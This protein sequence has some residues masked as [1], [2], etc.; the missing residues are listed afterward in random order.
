M[1]RNFKVFTNAFEPAF[2]VTFVVVVIY[3]FFNNNTI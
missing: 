2:E 3:L 1:I